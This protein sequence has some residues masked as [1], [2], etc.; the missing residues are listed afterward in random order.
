MTR[1][2]KHM[3]VFVWLHYLFASRSYKRMFH[4]SKLLNGFRL[5]MLLGVFIISNLANCVKSKLTLSWNQRIS[6]W[7]GQKLR[8][9]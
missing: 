5:E 6:S 8:I 7:R 1:K 3:R 2:G 9:W 4:T